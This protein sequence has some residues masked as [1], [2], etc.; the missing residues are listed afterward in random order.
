MSIIQKALEDSSYREMRSIIIE[1]FAKNMN[2]HPSELEKL[3]QQQEMMF[4]EGEKTNV[5]EN[6]GNLIINEGDK[7]IKG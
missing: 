7:I 1:A 5:A 2:I 3:M 4:L 6:T